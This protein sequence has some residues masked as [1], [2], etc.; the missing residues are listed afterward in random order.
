MPCLLQF[1][2]VVTEKEDPGLYFK[3]PFIQEVVPYDRRIQGFATDKLTVIFSDT[4]RL[5]IVAFARWQID[6]ATQLRQAAGTELAAQNLLGDR[7]NAQLRRVLGAV[8]TGEL[9]SAQRDA[10]M[11]SITEAVRDDAKAFGVA[12]VDVRIQSADL[13]DAN[14]QSTYERMRAERDRE[15]RDLRARG[16][17]RKLA[18]ESL[19][20]RES[21]ELV[22]KAERQAQIIRGLADGERNSI[23]REAYA[24]DAYEFFLF[25]EEIRACEAAIKAQTTSLVIS[26]GTDVCQLLLAEAGDQDGATETPVAPADPAP[27]NLEQ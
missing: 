17:E 4:R 15:A 19:A 12:V 7:I 5:E 6:S 18:L 3:I 26:P 16:A 11:R 24:G 2:Q 21:T 23:F 1:G 10:L 8:S 22:S 25:Y 14:L 20:E 27:T 13:P 9:L